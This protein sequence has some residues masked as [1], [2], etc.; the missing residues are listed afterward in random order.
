VKS[1]NDNTQKIRNSRICINAKELTDIYIIMSC[2]WCEIYNDAQCHFM[3]HLS[4]KPK[5]LIYKCIR[6]KQLF[7]VKWSNT[8]RNVFLLVFKIRNSLLINLFSFKCNDLGYN[9]P[10]I[11]CKRENSA[12]NLCIDVY[13][14]C[15]FIF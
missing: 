1:G 12:F 9:I 15:I 6:L 8:K 2:F 10:Y 7:L 11:A 13:I 5:S 14:Y 3:L 4:S